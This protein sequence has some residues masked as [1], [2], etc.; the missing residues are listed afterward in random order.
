M[1]LLVPDTILQ[2][3]VSRSRTDRVL[4]LIRPCR[5]WGHLHSLWEILYIYF[6]PIFFYMHMVLSWHNHQC[7]AR[8]NYISTFHGYIQV[9][10]V[11]LNL[12]PCQQ[13]EQENT[14][15]LFKLHF[16]MRLWSLKGTSDQ[17]YIYVHNSKK[18]LPLNMDKIAY[19][20]HTWPSS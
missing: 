17:V 8:Y 20:L 11:A 18:S 9:H 19:K 6:C 16:K 7:A 5:G 1:L 13:I 2:E 12:V 10:K 14:L 15:L 4:E 3:F